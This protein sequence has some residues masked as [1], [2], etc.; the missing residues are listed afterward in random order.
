MEKAKIY[1]RLEVTQKQV[2]LL[3]QCIANTKKY[4]SELDP[5]IYSAMIAGYE[6]LRDELRTEVQRYRTKL[7]L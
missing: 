7:D 1:K 5:R 4:E 3:E 6:S 2:D